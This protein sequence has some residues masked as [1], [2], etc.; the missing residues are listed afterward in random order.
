MSEEN[1][2]EE[3]TGNTNVT[4]IPPATIPP[5]LPKKGGRPKG[6]L[7]NEKRKMLNEFKRIWGDNKKKVSDRV[8]AAQLYADLMGWRVKQNSEVVGDKNVM[9]ISFKKAIK[10]P[11]MNKMVKQDEVETKIIPVCNETI[12]P[13]E[14]TTTTTILPCDNKCNET[15]QP[16]ED[17]FIEL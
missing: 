16:N 5:V 6:R 7:N 9:N 4:P 13:I 17:I 14:T 2:T 3:N 1:N 10:E 15:I 8:S 12:Q 11:A